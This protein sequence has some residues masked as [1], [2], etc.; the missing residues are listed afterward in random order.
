M[1]FIYLL[2]NGSDW[3]DMVI[4]LT[5]EEA[6]QES[7]KQPNIRIE[8]FSKNADGSVGYSPTYNFFKNGILHECDKV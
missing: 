7:I 8:I 4:L 3:E 5:E 1:N 6:I 2:I